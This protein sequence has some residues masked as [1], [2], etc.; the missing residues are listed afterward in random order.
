MNFRIMTQKERIENATTK[1]GGSVYWCLFLG[2]P[3][4]YRKSNQQG[5]SQAALVVHRD[6][7]SNIIHC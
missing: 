5:S 4:K 3:K 1:T 2:Y 6:N 7:G